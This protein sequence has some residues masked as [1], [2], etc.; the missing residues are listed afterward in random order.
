MD[1]NA[2][3]LQAATAALKLWSGAL[4]NILVP[5]GTSASSVFGVRI[6][7]TTH[8][9]RLTSQS[10]R[11]LDETGQELSCLHHLY[12]HGA[13]VAMPVPSIRN[14]SVERV[15]DYIATVFPRAPGLKVTPE[16]RLWNRE[17]FR[18]WGYALAF[19]HQAARS[20]RSALS[21]W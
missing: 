9:L 15:G 1:R 14:Q 13:C 20:F 4:P 5:C 10:F 16:T 18:E 2:S 21:G 3:I 8:F 12:S 6:N 19:Q 11:S 7:G 17:F